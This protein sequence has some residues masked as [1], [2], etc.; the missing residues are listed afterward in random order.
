MNTRSLILAAIL[1]T[2]GAPL[3]AAASPTN[4]DPAYV[5]APLS[6]WQAVQG[7][8]RAE[9]AGEDAGVAISYPLAS[10]SSAMMK[11]DSASVTP[12]NENAKE[13]TYALSSYP[14]ADRG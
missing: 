5:Y 4:H 14:T 2:L 8:M 9:P 1:A 3:V 7:G 10:Y 11:G 12:R 13:T 6:T